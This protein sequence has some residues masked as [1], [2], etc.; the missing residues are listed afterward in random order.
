MVNTLMVDLDGTLALNVTGRRFYGDGYEKHLYE[1]E[2]NPIVNKVI[3]SLY[4]DGTVDRVLFVSGRAEVGR[5]ETTRWLRDKAGWWAN[6]SILLM[7]PD[8]DY[9]QDTEVKYE[10]W[11]NHIKD[12]HTVLLALDDRPE[13]VAMWRSMDI[14]CWQVRDYQ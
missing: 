12:K 6:P 10:M 4:G 3:G 2:V 1:D 5:A 11:E 14:P 13:M 7:R 8:G 9:R